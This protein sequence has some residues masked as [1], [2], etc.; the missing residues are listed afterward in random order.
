MKPLE[1]Q[2][3]IKKKNFSP[4]YF[5]YGEES[6]LIEKMVKEMLPLL[7]PPGHSEFNLTVFYGKECTPRDILNAARTAPLLNDYRVVM[8]READ[9]LKPSSWSEFT[10]YFTT[11][12]PSTCL[13]FCA[14]KMV[15]K[16]ELDTF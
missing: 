8:L 12:V 2:K 9:Q 16:G 6:F 5:L 3:E 7:V 1:L 10:S 14:S 11:P 13:I 4:L 15:I